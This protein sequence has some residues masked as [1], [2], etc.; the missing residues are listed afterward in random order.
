VTQAG[1]HAPVRRVLMVAPSIRYLGGQAV[2][3]QRLVDSLR[4]LASVRV[5]SLVVDPALP[6]PLAWLQGIPIVRTLVTS[7]AYIVSLLRTVP[8]FDTIHIFSASYWSFLLAPTPALLI[9]RLFGKR[10]VLNYHSGEADDHLTRWGWHAKPLLRLADAIVVPTDYLVEV[11]RKHGLIA[12]PIA[13]HVDVG[14]M[15]VRER[16]CML[17][18]FFSNRNF[19]RHYNVSAIIDAFAVVQSVLP[20]AELVITGGGSQRDALEAHVAA[21]KLSHVTFTGPVPPASMPALYAAADVYVNASLIDN[22]PLSLLEAYASGLPVVTSDAGGIP[23][24]ARDGETARVV[25]AGNI[26]ALAAAMLDVV[27]R[28]GDAWERAR[29]AREFVTMRFS[30]DA[31]SAHWLQAYDDD[32]VV[33]S[34]V[35][36]ST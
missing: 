16:T 11:F 5:E 25:S 23:W 19:E 30:W 36:T 35:A 21:R 14:A 31:V 24:I 13:N 18:R 6:A 28:P 4:A 2:Q 9:G 7:T 29:R 27:Q 34:T 26:D 32:T 15:I 22:M 1:L 20:G 10:V 3:A 8:R 12:T 33:Q 17:P